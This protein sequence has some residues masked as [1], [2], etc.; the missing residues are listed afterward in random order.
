M[1]V[2]GYMGTQQTKNKTKRVVGGQAGHIVASNVWG[3]TD[4]KDDVVAT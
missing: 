3:E 2:G 1:G 4:Q